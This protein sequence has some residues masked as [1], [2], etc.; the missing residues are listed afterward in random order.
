MFPVTGFEFGHAVTAFYLNSKNT[1]EYHFLMDGLVN[2][3]KIKKD[4]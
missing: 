2:Y 1:E 4:W 3:R